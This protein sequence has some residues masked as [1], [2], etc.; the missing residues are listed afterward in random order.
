MS[1]PTYDPHPDFRR[2]TGPDDLYTTK[3]PWDIDQ[4]QPAFAQL[5]DAGKYHGRV[6]DIG[7][8]TGEH[9]LLAA[10]LGLDATGI[11]QSEQ[12]IDRAER[13]RAIAG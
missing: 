4:P 7:C 3:P 5:A 12:A 13:K 11:D 2:P 1:V 8:G 9:A 6:L 10:R